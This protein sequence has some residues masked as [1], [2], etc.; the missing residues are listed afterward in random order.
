ML[1]D[2]TVH[3]LAA[4]GC[5]AYIMWKPESMVY[6]R[7]A[8]G[9]M[10]FVKNLHDNRRVCDH[11]EALTERVKRFIVLA[12]QRDPQD[13][14]LRR[15]EKRWTGELSEVENPAHNVAYSLG[16]TG[17][18]LCVREKSGELARV[19]ACMYVLLHELAHVAT[20]EYGHTAAFWTNMKYL[21][22]MAEAVG[23]YTHDEEPAM[24]CGKPLVESPMACVKD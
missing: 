20:P 21:L 23:V 17:I 15:I 2:R 22:E 3:M 12:R 10:Y 13:P 6:A 16:K 5:A 24:L 1:D 7:S 8:T 9:N 19:N 18:H 11:L 4:V 14:R